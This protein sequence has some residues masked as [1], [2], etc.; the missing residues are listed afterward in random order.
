MGLDVL[1][2]Y[3]IMLSDYCIIQVSCGA[4]QHQGGVS[5]TFRQTWII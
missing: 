1:K 2:K 4:V 5:S 3:Y